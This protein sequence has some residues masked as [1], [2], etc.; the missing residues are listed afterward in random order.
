M[1]DPAPA[2]VTLDRPDPPGGIAVCRLTGEIDL[3]DHRAVAE[4]FARATALATTA[5]V[6]D[7]EGLAFCDSTLLNALLGLRREAAASGLRLVLAAPTGQLLRLLEISGVA[8]LLPAHPTL[9][10]AL[11]SLRDGGPA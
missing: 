6:V 1:P 8:G 10:R 11:E 2:P 9:G 3:D 5:V 7:C 4:A